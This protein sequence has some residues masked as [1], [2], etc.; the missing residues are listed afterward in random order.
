M[1][2]NSSTFI[3]EKTR[4]LPQDEESE[5]GAETQSARSSTRQRVIALCK[6]GWVL[7]LYTFGVVLVQRAF[8]PETQGLSIHGVTLGG[9]INGILPE[10]PLEVSVFPNTE[11]LYSA[12]GT[13]EADSLKVR[14]RWLEL[15]PLGR[16]QV[17]IKQEQGSHLLKPFSLH[18]SRVGKGYFVSWV[19]Q[20]HCLYI[21]MNEWDEAKQYGFDGKEDYGHLSHCWDYLRHTILCSMDMTL[22]GEVEHGV[23]I[24]P[25]T[26]HVCRNYEAGK[27]QVEAL[28]QSDELSISLSG[29][30]R[31]GNGG[32]RG[33]LEPESR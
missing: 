10:L 4:F 13:S 12:N 33:E 7:A 22:E 19:H 5:R 30:L 21:M 11:G 9:D 23:P 8:I 24:G 6:W 28:R 16:G 20:L 14:R 32:I 2:P 18:P 17:G 26:T 15:F 27:S 31:I 3:G 25:G 29:E 1:D